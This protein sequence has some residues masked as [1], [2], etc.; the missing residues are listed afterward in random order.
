LVPSEDSSGGRERRGAIT[1]TGNPHAR[2]VTV[3]GVWHYRHAP[4]VGKGLK[5][6]QQG[7]PESIIQIAY[8]AQVRLHR[9]Y[10]RL[11]RSG[12]PIQKV[13]VALAREWLGFVWA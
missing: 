12:K 10:Q 5:K 6:R 9:R 4:R 2:R 7:L 8:R 1:K 13:V 3:E 11:L